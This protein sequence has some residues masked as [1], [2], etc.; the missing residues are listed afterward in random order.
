M[1]NQSGRKGGIACASTMSARCAPMASLQ[2]GGDPGGADP[3]SR[4]PPAATGR[5]G[6]AE[7]GGCEAG[8]RDPIGTRTCPIPRSPGTN[9]LA[10]VRP[11]LTSGRA[12]FGC[13]GSRRARLAPASLRSALPPGRCLRRAP[14]GSAPPGS[15]PCDCPQ[16]S[17]EPLSWHVA[18]KRARRQLPALRAGRRPQGGHRAAAPPF[19][20]FR[21]ASGAQ[22]AH[23]RRA[24]HAQPARARQAGRGAPLPHPPPTR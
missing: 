20:L 4:T 18:R 9:A 21:R 5:Q 14:R 22:A 12:P 15:P 1:L 19:E 17:P 10:R 13:L 7:R 8:A 11:D 16:P 6:R 23:L 2:A 24:G 3:R